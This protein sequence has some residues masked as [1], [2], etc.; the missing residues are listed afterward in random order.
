MLSH[1][2]RILVGEDVEAVDID[3]AYPLAVVVGRDDKVL[4]GHD[5]V[6]GMI[7]DLLDLS[8]YPLKETAREED[9]SD[10]PWQCLPATRPGIP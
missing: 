7:I 1:L 8:L 10:P 9:S 6:E 4:A 2:G 5:H 3:L